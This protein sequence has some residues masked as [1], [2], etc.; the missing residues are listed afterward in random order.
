VL[1]VPGSGAFNRDNTFGVSGTDRDHLGLHLS[2]RFRKAGLAVVR[3]DQRGVDHPA[4]PER[5]TRETR[6]SLTTRALTDDLGTVLDWTRD[7][8]GLAARRVVLLAHSEG[9]SLAARLSERGC[10]APDLLLGLCG[11]MESQVSLLRRL[12]EEEAGPAGYEQY[13]CEALTH[14]DDDPWPTPENVLASF[15][16]WRNWFLDDVPTARRLQG[17]SDVCQLH[18]GAADGQVPPQHQVPVADSLLPGVPV[19]VHPGL[20][21]TLGS[22]PQRGPM[23][24]GVLDELVQ[25]AVAACRP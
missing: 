2:L 25:A 18:F 4:A 22:D 11:P 21:H 5:P 20:G 1:L 17:W 14:R 24:D 6:L 3:D 9:V 13:R 7:P 23:D 12:I 10:S 15:E 16:W 8:A 19:T